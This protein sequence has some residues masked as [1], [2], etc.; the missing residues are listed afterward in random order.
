MAILF[1]AAFSVILSGLCSI[2]ETVLFSARPMNLLRQRERP[3]VE[4]FITIKERHIGDAVSVTLIVNTVAGTVGP[5]FV[6]ASAA[7]IWGGPAV[8]ISSAVLTVLIVVLAEIAPKTY[9]ATHAEKFAGF[10]GYVLT[11]L[12]KVFRPIL[13]VTRWITAWLAG[14]GSE[15]ITRNG[16][17]RIIAYAPSMGVLSQGESDVLAHMLFAHGVTLADAHTPLDSVASFPASA[18]ADALMHARRHIHFARIPLHAEKQDALIGYI[19]QREVLQRVLSEPAA[20]ALPLSSFLHP[21]PV[22]ERHLPVGQAIASLLDRRQPI[23]AVAEGGRI[24]GIATLEDLFEVLL[25]VDITDEG[26][27]II[28]Q[29]PENDS[30]R[31]DRLRQ[32]RERRRE[33][34]EDA[35]AGSPDT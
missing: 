8:G 19:N 12:L 30:R 9:A 11:I 23:G 10:T 5:M 18:T 29:R 32:L 6:G 15:T 31:R 35:A 33:W 25:G 34:A 14:E 27:D 24:I 22:L 7:R 13:P 21:L 4:A 26:D 28:R 16:L 1:W 17:A 3:G 2:L 20:R